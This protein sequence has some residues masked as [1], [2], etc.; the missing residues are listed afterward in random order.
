MTMSVHV[1]MLYTTPENAV[2]FDEYYLNSHMPLAN[3]IPGVRSSRTGVVLGSADGSPSVYHRLTVMQFDDADSV[4]HAFA[5][6]EGRLAAADYASFAPEGS[7]M[8]LWD[9]SDGSPSA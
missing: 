9:D 7:M 1:V 2:E 8:V 5:S 4:G 3:S 6:E